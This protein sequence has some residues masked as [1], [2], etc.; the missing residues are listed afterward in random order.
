MNLN[1]D[2][3]ALASADIESAAQQHAE[4]SLTSLACLAVACVPTL[5]VVLAICPAAVQAGG[6][7][8]W[9][10]GLLL[11]L[12][13]HLRDR[14][15]GLA[16]G[17]SLLSVAAL[18]VA[19]VLSPRYEGVVGAVC[20]GWLM[21]GAVGHSSVNFEARQTKPREIYSNSPSDAVEITST[22]LT[23]MRPI[24]MAVVA[25]FMAAPVV[26]FVVGF[27]ALGYGFACYKFLT[28]NAAVGTACMGVV[29]VLALN[30]YLLDAECWTRDAM[31]K[32]R[33]W[34]MVALSALFACGIL[35]QVES[36]G[37]GPLCIFLLLFVGYVVALK[38]LVLGAAASHREYVGLLATP[39]LALAA[40]VFVW[41]VVWTNQSSGASG[42]RMWS[43]SVGAEHVNWGPDT[44]RYYAQKMDCEV[45]LTEE[46][47][48][49]VYS[50]CLGAFLLWATPAAVA[51]A[52]F[53][54]ALAAHLLD[55]DDAHGTPK[56]AVQLIFVFLFGVWCTASLS[57]AGAVITTAVFAFI[58]AGL[59]A[60]FGFVAYA[61]GLEMFQH[62]TEQSFVQKLVHK[63]GGMADVLRGL[64][65]VT[66]VPVIGGFFAASVL[67]QTLRQRPWLRGITKPLDDS[68]R[69]LRLT[70]V[71]HGL[72][73]SMG[74]WQWT[75]V[76]VYALYWGIFFFT[77][78][79]IISKFTVL[80]LSW[81][82][83]CIQDFSLLVV[84]AIFFGIGFLMFMAPPI[85]G[86]PVYLTSGIILVA[87]GEASMG[88]AGSILYAFVFCMVLKLLSALGQMY[89]FGVPLGQVVAVRRA[90]G[91]N[92][93]LVRSMKLVLS[94]PGMSMAK[95]SILTGGPDW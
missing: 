24:H 66:C 94:E 45:E 80:F 54:F 42:Y 16:V 72:W 23:R 86:V 21:G 83:I 89:V 26:L 1:T 30:L 7:V 18:V 68:D 90:V 79:V 58:L 95:V 91:V 32:V 47:V 13:A 84:S 85:P 6:A 19:I 33:Q 36:Y 22:S 88:L 4:V 61:F 20:G 3:E 35:M 29:G 2:G 49:D 62:P 78:N 57:G 8:G 67:N 37:Y 46:A 50:S 70:K 92:S 76:L 38:P 17:V 53:V 55:P 56:L 77:C 69:L 87:A 39:L 71:G 75:P 59:L 73:V 40:F 93:Q 82:I 65:V 41:W 14:R 34:S 64:F 63:Y 27:S 25:V 9:A 81:L 44:K 43:P 28:A 11:S 5:V 74:H 12:G 10:C 51:F 31:V 60:V 48:E 52:L 15:A